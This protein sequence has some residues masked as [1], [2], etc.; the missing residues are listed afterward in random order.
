MPSSPASSELS[1]PPAAKRRR[2]SSTS[3][4]S[5]EDE[6]EDED[7]DRPLAARIALKT[8][9]RVENGASRV[10]TSGKRC[11]KKSSSMKSK[12][13]SASVSVQTPMSARVEVNGMANGLNGHDFKVKSEERMD[14]GQL[15]R[16]ATGVT[17]DAGGDPGSVVSLCLHIFEGSNF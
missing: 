5:E 7:E 17:V 2:L 3:S 14:E 1:E 15:D 11:G 10:P 8:A 12:A 4:L 6:D 13:Q 9:Q 16:L